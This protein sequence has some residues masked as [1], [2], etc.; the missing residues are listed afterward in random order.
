MLELG[1]NWWRWRWRRKLVVIPL[2]LLVLHL[3]SLLLQG[4]F[5]GLLDS[6]SH[7][8]TTAVTTRTV[9]LTSA[10]TMT[11]DVSRPAGRAA[12]WKH[13]VVPRMLGDI[14]GHDGRLAFRDW[15]GH[16]TADS[17]GL[18]LVSG[19]AEH[20]RVIRNGRRWLFR[21]SVSVLFGLSS[22]GPRVCW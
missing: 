6:C 20:E 5:K 14:G 3:L 9:E 22:H 19:V 12:A 16:G 13:W 15:N 10:L 8:R 11:T 7:R 17:F 4:S 2:V 18:A 21:A 1:E